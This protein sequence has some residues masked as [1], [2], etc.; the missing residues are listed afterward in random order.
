MDRRRF[1]SALVG[2]SVAA[3]G[4][5]G[6]SVGSLAGCLDRLR[7]RNAR[8]GSLS[9]VNLHDEPHAVELRV[10]RDGEEVFRRTFDLAESDHYDS[11]QNPVPVVR[12]PWMDD[13]AQFRVSA[14]LDDREEWYEKQ[15]P[16]PDRP[17]P[18]YGAS[19]KIG[20]RGVLTMPYDAHAGTC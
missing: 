7:Y 20:T 11:G 9:L 19:V 8:I 14:R 10:V 4:V 15:F 16:N 12:E 17:G 2:R 18:C 1:L 13:P 3:T 6:I 5:A